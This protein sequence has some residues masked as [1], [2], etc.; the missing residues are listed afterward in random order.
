MAQELSQEDVQLTGLVFDPNG[1]AQKSPIGENRAN[2]EEGN[3]MVRKLIRNQSL[4]TVAG[5]TPVPS[6]L[7]APRHSVTRNAEVCLLV[8]LT[9]FFLLAV[10]F[11]SGI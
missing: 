2:R 8:R 6:A 3:R 11:R 9:A 4:A 7:M 10:G 5:S 1:L